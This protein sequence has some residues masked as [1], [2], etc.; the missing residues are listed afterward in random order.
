MK[1][2]IAEYK[3]IYDPNHEN[4]PSGNW[5]R[6]NSGWSTNINNQP[7]LRNV[8]TKSEQP[9]KKNKNQSQQ[10]QENDTINEN[11]NID[12][13]DDFEEEKIVIQQ[14]EENIDLSDEQEEESIDLGDEQEEESLD[15]GNEQEEE[16]LDLGGEQ[17]SQ[18]TV[19]DNKNY[20]SDEERVKFSNEQLYNSYIEKMNSFIEKFD[21]EQGEKNNITFKAVASNLDWSK[22]DDAKAFANHCKKQNISGASEIIAF[23]FYQYNDN[24]D[25]FEKILSEMS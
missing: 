18:Q 1:Q 7:L 21:A 23:L 22:Q 25:N 19:D 4:K 8:K 20:F 3:Y 15:L 17:S 12:I 13:E 5:N 10:K 24:E 11:E 9:I 2:I 16:S 14:E 6:T